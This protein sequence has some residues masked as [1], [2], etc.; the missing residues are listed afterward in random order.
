MKLV[1]TTP[2]RVVVS[3]DEVLAVR[4]EDE[5]GSFGILPGHAELLTVLPPSVVSWRGAD[6]STGFC[7]VARGVLTVRAGREVAIAA[8][9]A[10]PGGNLGTLAEQVV[11]RFRAEADAERSARVAAMQ[12][13]MKAL[14]QIMQML[15]PERRMN[16]GM[17]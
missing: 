3:Q 7:A 17:P 4:A 5:S 10:V 6:G 15:R 8:R 14:R 12:L 16:G 2:G 9:Q 11:E 13:Q 1:I